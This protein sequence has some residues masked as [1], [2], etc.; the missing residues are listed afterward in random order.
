MSMHNPPPPGEFI[1]SIYMEPYELSC[2][3]LAE[4]LGVV[5]SAL[6]RV[7][8]GK[9]ASTFFVEKVVYAAFSLNNKAVVRSYKNHK[10]VFL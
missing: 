1:E 7:I 4:Q 2:R 10:G 5:A 8:K 6:N 3:Y 9:S